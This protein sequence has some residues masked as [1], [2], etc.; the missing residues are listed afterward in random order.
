MSQVNVSKIQHPQEVTRRPVQIASAG[1]NIYVNATGAD[2]TP[3][4]SARIKTA[5]ST[6]RSGEVML[7]EPTSQSALETH[8]ASFKS[9][10]NGFRIGGGVRDSIDVR[11]TTLNSNSNIYLSDGTVK[12]FNASTG[13]FNLDI[14]NAAANSIGVTTSLNA[15]MQTGDQARVTV[16]TGT[17]SSSGTLNNSGFRIDGSTVT[18]EW[19]DNDNPT[20]GGETPGPGGPAGYDVFSFAITK[21]GNNSWNVIGIFSHFGQED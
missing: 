4:V 7:G 16:I 18:V 21:T 11:G 10:G 12:L 15:K 2:L 8:N 20:P 19:A 6:L 14:T 5:S 17:T 3:T 1:T 9:V 13:N